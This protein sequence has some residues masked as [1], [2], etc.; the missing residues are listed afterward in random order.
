MHK[1]ERRLE[2]E[3]VSKKVDNTIDPKKSDREGSMK[4]KK[5]PLDFDSKKHLPSNK[6][7]FEKMETPKKED[8]VMPKNSLITPQNDANINIQPSQFNP[9]GNTPGSIN[10]NLQ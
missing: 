8:L 9:Y 2:K 4:V 10:K 6:M 7:D 1:E 5:N 3:K